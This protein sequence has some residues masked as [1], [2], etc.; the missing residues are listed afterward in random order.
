MSVFVRPRQLADPDVRLIVFHHAAGSSS[1]YFG[2]GRH[3]P[4]GCELLLLDL[5][6]RG[7]RHRDPPH[8]TMQQIVAS[9]VRDIEPFLDRPLALFG[10]SLGAVIAFETAH[11]LQARGVAPFWLGVSG[12]QGPGLV[13]PQRKLQE[14]PDQALLD[15]LAGL[16]GMPGRFLEAPDFLEIVL[17]NA[18][19]DFAA[20]DTYRASPG[21]PKLDV[22]LTAYA[23]RQDPWAP[24][25]MMECWADETSR[26]FTLQQYDGG[27][28]YFLGP[29]LASLASDIGRQI[30]ERS[31]VPAA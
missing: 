1:T 13:T 10:H 20:I 28:F 11:M 14:L 29:T 24:P 18:R 2:L 7:K 31:R 6:G 22:A 3:M 21:R 15:E 25:G 27:H 4:P 8:H 16:G 12:R 26:D 23:G 19:A 17:R 5:P 9:V 30:E